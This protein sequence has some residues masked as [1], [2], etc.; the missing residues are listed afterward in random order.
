MIF[1]SNPICR[2]C[3][4]PCLAEQVVQLNGLRRLVEL[5]KNED[6]RLGSDGVLVACLAAV[7]KV[8]Q[9]GGVLLFEDTNVT[10][11]LIGL[12]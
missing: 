11:G 7:R 9:I 10:A 4:D 5:C 1:S 6:A 8:S 12:I 2:L 3:N